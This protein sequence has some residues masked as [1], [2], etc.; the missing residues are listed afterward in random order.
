MDL[1]KQRFLAKL[2]ETEKASA[3]F[4]RPVFLAVAF[5]LVARKN[6]VT[7]LNTGFRCISGVRVK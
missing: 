6:K 5:Y 7:M 4:S 2:S 3:D 1:Y